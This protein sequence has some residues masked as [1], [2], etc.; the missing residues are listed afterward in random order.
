MGDSE[1]TIARNYQLGA[2][3]RLTMDRL[4]FTG[5]YTTFALQESNPA[6]VDY[7]TDSAASGTGWAT[8]HKTS[9][10]RIAT[11][12]GTTRGVADSNHPRARSARRYKV[13]N[14]TTAELTDATPAVL[15]SHIN[16]RNCQGPAD[17]GS[18]A[19]YK[20]EMGGPGSIAEQSVD[21]RVD[22]LLGGGRDRFAQTITGGPFA[23]QTVIQAAQAHWL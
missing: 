16:N 9:N 23:G 20:K 12:A 21:H 11:V 14:V 10:G 13:G 18:C 6:L 22:V 1:I 15:D 3:G 17:M 2:R 7:V 4:P 5:A 19:A 8:G